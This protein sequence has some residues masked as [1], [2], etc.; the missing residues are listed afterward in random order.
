MLD[1]SFDKSLTFY[2][3]KVEETAR[4]APDV[5]AAAR[6]SLEKDFVGEDPFNQNMRR[7]LGLF[8]RHVDLFRQNK[9]LPREAMQKELLERRFQ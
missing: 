1:T 3:S 5:L 6:Q 7:N 2:R 8:R 4:L 9:P